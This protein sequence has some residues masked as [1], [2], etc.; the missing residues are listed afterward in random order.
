[1]LRSVLFHMVKQLAICYSV[2]YWYGATIS[3]WPWKSVK[4]NSQL[5][6]HICHMVPTVLA[7]IK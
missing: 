7:A 4:K 3:W 2:N 6:W 1:M 5:F